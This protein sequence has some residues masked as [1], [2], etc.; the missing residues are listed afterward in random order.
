[1]TRPVF[2]PTLV[3]M[4]QTGTYE[5]RCLVPTELHGRGLLNNCCNRLCKEQLLNPKRGKG[6][7]YFKK[8]QR[9]TLAVG[10]DDALVTKASPVIKSNE[11]F[12]EE[13][14]LGFSS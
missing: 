14:S 3:E 8:I 2:E 12:S 10:N 4:H 6:C 13:S 1:M 11:P 5:G 7:P 9:S